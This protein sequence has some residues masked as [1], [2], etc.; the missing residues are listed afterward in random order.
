MGITIV[1]TKQATVFMADTTVHELP[2]PKEMADIAIQAAATARVMG[3]EP[4]VAFLSYSNFGKPMREKMLPVREAVMEM[5]LREVDFEYD[6]DM[7][8]EVA[9]DRE[10]M[11]TL[12]PFCRLS[13][14]ANVLIMPG[15][16][17][18]NIASQLVQKL[19][20]GTVIGPLLLGLRRSAQIVQIGATVGEIVNMAALAAADV[21]AEARAP[22]RVEAAAR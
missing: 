7:S 19:G 8:A 17:S 11:R 3:H 13:G 2:S 12:Y 4:R 20:G 10:L 14:P 18:A 22:A 15:L 21:R 9:L 1:V 16:H 6:G 5:D